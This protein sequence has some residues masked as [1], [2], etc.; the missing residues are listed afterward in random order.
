MK[1][2]LNFEVGDGSGAQMARKGSGGWR[3]LGVYIV[4]SFERGAPF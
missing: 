2:F 3:D 1:K 4:Y